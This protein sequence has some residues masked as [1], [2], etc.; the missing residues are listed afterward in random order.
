MDIKYKIRNNAIEVI[1]VGKLD[2]N[3][4]EEFEKNIIS[5]ALESDKKMIGINLEKLEYI[6]S[7]GLGVLIKLLNQSKNKNKEFCVFG[8]QPKIQNI[9]QIS[10]LEKFFTFISTVE[11]KS[12][13]PSSDDKALDSFIESL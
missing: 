1:P 13:Y 5:N 3:E 6:D 4:T 10:R 11:F 8:A 7:S 12:K 9:F 2:I